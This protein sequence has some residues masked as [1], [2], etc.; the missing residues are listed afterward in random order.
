MNVGSLVDLLTH[1]EC[2]WLVVPHAR[3]VP[4]LDKFILHSPWQLHQKTGDSHMWLFKLQGLIVDACAFSSWRPNSIFFHWFYT[5]VP[6]TYRAGLLSSNPPTIPELQIDR[7]LPAAGLFISSYSIMAMTCVSVNYYIQ[8][9]HTI[10]VACQPSC[11][12]SSPGQ[13]KVLSSIGAMALPKRNLRYIRRELHCKN[14]HLFLYRGNGFSHTV[15]TNSRQRDR[16]KNHCF[17]LLAPTIFDTAQ[18]RKSLECDATTRA[19][20]VGLTGGFSIV[21]F[22]PMSRLPGACCNYREVYHLGGIQH[23]HY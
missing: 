9:H 4:T 7:E 12:S 15:S 23:R 21:T 6:S 11:R 10:F 3:I 19:A 1:D 18:D 16:R 2:N 13:L 5:L 14:L 20:C 8:C 22:L 17:G